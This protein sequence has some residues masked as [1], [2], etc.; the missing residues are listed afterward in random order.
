MPMIGTMSLR[1][2]GAV[3]VREQVAGGRREMVMGSVVRIA[4][5]M[6]SVA[7]VV[8][9]AGTVCG[10]DLQEAVRGLVASKKLGD[11][12][13]GI[14]LMDAH[15]KTVLASVNAGETFIPAS[16]MKLLTS[17]AAMMGAGRG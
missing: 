1:M 5:V 15:S 11:A 17:G 9:M 3:F 7:V 12:K 2:H 16:N 6:A 8:A 14:C 13:V 10:Q 4:R